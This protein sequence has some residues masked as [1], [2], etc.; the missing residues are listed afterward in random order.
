MPRAWIIIC[1]LIA[2]RMISVAQVD[3][4]IIRKEVH[5]GDTMYVVNAEPVFILGP[6][7][8]PSNQKK[9]D[10]DRYTRLV[11]NIKKVYPY[12]KKARV[13]IEEMNKELASYKD[14]RDKKEYIKKKEKALFDQY[15][16]E[17][18]NL[19]ISQG[20]LLIKLI[21]R[22][23]TITTYDL[24]KEY[25]GPIT[26]VFW[27]GIARIVGS[28]LKVTYEPYGED[29]LIEEIIVLVEKGLL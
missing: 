7:V 27:Q 9:K 25:K 15:E 13:M 22:E 14:E 12:A 11:F 19:T 2:S 6:N 4:S 18:K 3:T 1:C 28:N 24:I 16:A 29:Q 26:A 10:Y 21:D 17:L 8:K 20:K 23:T 5:N